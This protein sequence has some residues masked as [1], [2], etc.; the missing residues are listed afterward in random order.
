MK[1]LSLILLAAAAAAALP[2]HAD[3]KADIAAIRQVG[4][5]GK[6]NPQAGTAW[7]SLAKGDAKSITSLL[8][9]MDDANDLAANYL[10]SAV[11]AIVDRELAA[12]R[13]LPQLDLE[14]FISDT[15]HNPRA[16][17]L[18]YELIARVSPATGEKL[19]PTFLNDPSVELR[20]DAV[21]QLIDAADKA[22]A[23]QDKAAATKE[24][25]NALTYA[26]DEAQIK[27]VAGELRKLEQPVDLPKHFGFLTHWK[28]IGSFDNAKL[29][30]FD[31]A[32]PP[33]KEL[34]L[35]AIYDGKLEKARWVDVATANDYGMVDFNKPFGDLKGVTGYAFTEFNAAAARPAE[36]R[37]GCKNG[38]K[39]W[40]NG[41]LLFGRDEYHRGARID[42]YRLP[43]ELKAGR[44]TI[45]VK[46]CQNE[47]VK[48]WTKE[49]EFQL[50]VCDASGTA[51]L[52]KDR[53]ATPKGPAG[54][55]K[56]EAKKGTK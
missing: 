17:R 5:E 8:A 14:K 35:A 16:R 21:Q 42:Q 43:V 36:L 20:R 50:R 27:K 15:K 25:S 19:L 33:E 41:K 32:Y 56:A 26:R 53:P 18:A 12:K 6:G 51:I 13:T 23:A 3:F 28:L 10:R 52:A 4:G 34:N 2:A 40:F 39:V 30:G 44:N 7:H 9:A 55:A 29:V 46:V 37:L 38:W 11:D 48:D 1:P 24:F 49:W 45:L 22:L 31:T 47:D 54:A